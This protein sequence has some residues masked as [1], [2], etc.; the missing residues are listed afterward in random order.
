[1]TAE[2]SMQAV[3]GLLLLA[4]L[5]FLNQREKKRVE[6][7]LQEQKTGLDRRNGRSKARDKS[8]LY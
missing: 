8:F 7:A 6:P 5:L 3:V 4:L 1:M 2:S